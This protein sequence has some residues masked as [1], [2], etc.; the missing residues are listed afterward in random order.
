[1]KF[2]PMSEK[3]IQALT[4]MPDGVYPFDVTDAKDCVSKAGNEQIKITLAVYDN[5]NHKH[6]LYD[7]L[8][9]GALPH[10]IRHFC[11]H[12][13]LLSRY[14]AGE[15]T[16]ADCYQKSGWV[17]I[18]TESG[19]PNPNGGEYPARNVVRDYCE[20]PSTS[21]GSADSKLPMDDIPF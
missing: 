4:V 8:L 11:E 16:A 1:M 18:G 9:N 21:A 5:A 19:K 15:L 3:E 20:K 14:D 12:T 10:K 7:Y 13:G 17:K 6:V 2:T